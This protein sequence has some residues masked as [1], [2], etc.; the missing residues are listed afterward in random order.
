MLEPAG[1]NHGVVSARASGRLDAAPP[2][3]PTRLYSANGL[4]TG[5]D[6]RIYVAQVGGSQI[7]AVDPDTGAVEIISPMG[8]AITAPDDLAFDEA[9]NPTPPRS[10]KAA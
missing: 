10:P 3:P 6:G 5:P 2:D 7:S 9:G 4:R 8:G 1:R